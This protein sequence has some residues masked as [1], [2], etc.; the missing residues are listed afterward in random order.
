MFLA[1]FWKIENFRLFDIDNPSMILRSKSRKI[2]LA[3]RKLFS[4]ILCI[5][6]IYTSIWTRFMSKLE[7]LQN[8]WIK[9]TCVEKH[10]VGSGKS[11]KS[12]F[13]Q[14]K[15]GGVNSRKKLISGSGKNLKTRYL[16]VSNQH[17][18]I[19]SPCTPFKTAKKIFRKFV[20]G[21]YFCPSKR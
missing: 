13:R 16:A 8:L 2:F 20:L 3:P 18:L 9:N 12:T 21:N 4:L 5:S 6:H 10:F 11:K 1:K 19:W 15:R 17:V 7:R 14:T